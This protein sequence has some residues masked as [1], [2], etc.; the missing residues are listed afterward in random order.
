[1]PKRQGIFQKGWIVLFLLT[2]A[3]GA[4][5]FPHAGQF[6]IAEDPF[7]QADMALVLS[8]IPVDRSLGARDLYRQNRIG[9]I[10]VI[11]EFKVPVNQELVKLGLITP[12]PLQPPWSERILIASGVPREKIFF[13]PEPVDGTINEALQVRRYLR[14][15]GF[16]DGKT[17]TSLVLVTSRYASR[18]ARFIFQWILRGE[19]VKVLSFPT[20]YGSY[21]P[22]QWWRK[23]RQALSV[24]MEYQKFLCNGLT[25]LFRFY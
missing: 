10:L 18:R 9:R 12:G 20:P 2:A 7:T 24:V 17:P 5:F 4:G 21:E 1:M 23:P 22:D 19:K 13:L 8:G 11:P 25:L 14:E 3:A 15:K 16:T 6:L